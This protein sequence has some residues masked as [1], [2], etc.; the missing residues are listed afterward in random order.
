[1]H[2]LAHL[3]GS[4]KGRRDFIDN[5]LDQDATEGEEG[6]ANRQASEWLLL[7]DAFDDF[8]HRTQPNFSFASHPSLRKGPGR[9]PGARCRP[10]STTKV[11][12]TSAS[13]AAMLGKVR[14]LFLN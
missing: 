12:S 13:I 14:H 9:S 10:G 11:I 1:M 4:S 7:K 8:V 5:E 3:G 2:E 6:Q